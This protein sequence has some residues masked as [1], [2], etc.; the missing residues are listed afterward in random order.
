MSLTKYQS[1]RHFNLTPEP[2]GTVNKKQEP[3]FVVQKHAASHL[4]YDFRL[5]VDGVLKSWAVPKGPCL[6]PSIKRLAVAVEDHPLDY[7]TFEGDIPAHEYG[8]GSV[9]VWDYGIWDA[10]TDLAKSYADGVMQ[11]TLSGH[12][13]SGE[14]RLIKLP[15]AMSQ[16]QWLLIKVK[17]KYARKLSEYDVLEAEPDSVLSGK[18]LKV[19]KHA[20]K[21]SNQQLIKQKVRKKTTNKEIFS[22]TFN[23]QLATLSNIVPS[24]DQWIYETKFDGYRILAYLNHQDVKLISRNNQDWTNKFSSVV[25]DLKKLN[26]SATVLDGEMVILDNKNVSN[27]QLL[28]NVLSGEK[29]QHNLHYFIFDV[30]VYQGQD[31]TSLQLKERKNL[32]QSSFFNQS[33][34]HIHYT[35]HLQGDAKQLL[36]AAC[37]AGLEGIIAKDKT[38]IYRQARTQNWLKLK[39]H[40]RQEFIVLGYTAPSGSRQYF[41]SLLVGYYDDKH[42]LKYAG[43]VG[44]GFNQRSLKSIYDKLISIQQDIMPLSKKPKDPLLRKIKWVKPELIVEVSFSEWTRDGILRHPSFQGLRVDKTSA[45]ISQE[46]PLTENNTVQSLTHPDKIVYPKAGITKLDLANYFEKI[47]DNILPFVRNRPLTILRCPSGTTNQCFLQKNWTR[48]LP[49]GLLATSISDKPSATEYI[50][51]RNK[52]GLIDLA[53]ISTLEIHP[54]ASNNMK[55]DYPDQ[56]IFDLD[57]DINTSWQL[58]IEAA[59]ILHE[60]LN[61]LKLINYVKLTGGK[62]L[63]LVVPLQGSQKYDEI[64]KFAKVMAQKLTKYYPKIFTDNLI[65]KS[66]VNKIFIDYLRNEK[67]ATAVAPFSPRHDEDASIAVPIAWD[68]LSQIKNSKAFNIRT[69]DEYFKKHSQNPWQDFFDIKQVISKIDFKVLNNM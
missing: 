25:A 65:K 49:Q 2:K 35:E 15:N 29:S 55:L 56:M 64:K 22:M 42:Q 68:K 50:S 48:G 19:T 38:S 6:D 41:G 69:I 4:H 8:A 67:E 24:G 31:I 37:K 60:A 61:N 53:Q 28:Q 11:F 34:S 54:W 1:K 39:C 9:I 63:H 3:I 5:A 17:D 12:K 30:L 21:S 45:E 36:N 33:F 13:L 40:Q 43:H 62:G 66:R 10:K 18:K 52:K 46:V 51:L 23:P 16:P 32:L 59:N 58:I 26:L 57:P 7:A 14:W 20:I 27:F 44:T 47:A